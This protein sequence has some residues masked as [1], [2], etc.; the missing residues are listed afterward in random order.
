S[1]RRR[2]TRFSRDWSSDVCSSD[3]SAGSVVRTKA[4]DAAWPVR[5]GPRHC[6]QSSAC[7]K[8]MAKR[9]AQ[10]GRDE[11]SMKQDSLMRDR[12]QADYVHHPKSEGPEIRGPKEVRMSKSEKSTAYDLFRISA[13]FRP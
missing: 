13:F 11:R 5:S 6:G 3:L 8:E 7:K 1:S 4:S 12:R 9:K 10:N 2:H